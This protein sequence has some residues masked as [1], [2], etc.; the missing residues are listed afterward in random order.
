MPELLIIHHSAIAIP[1]NRQRRTFDEQSIKEL[2]D[3]LASAHGQLHP[4]VLRAD[5][6]TLVCGERRL[7]AVAFLEHSGRS[8]S[9]RDPTTGELTPLPEGCLL[10]HTIGELSTDELEEAELSENI[11]RVDLT[12]QE[13]VEAK[14]RLVRLR[15]KQ[16]PAVTSKEIAKELSP[17]AVPTPSQVTEAVLLAENLHRPEVSAA[18]NAKAAM[19][20]LTRELEHEFRAELARRQDG[21]PLDSRHTLIMGNLHAEL[22]RIASSTVDCIIADPPYGIN[23]DTSFGDMAELDHEYC[24][25]P[26]QADEIYCTLAREGWRI[27]KDMAHAYIF[28]DWTWWERVAEVFGA[29]GWVVWPRPL[30]W[31]K[32]TG[33]LPHPHHGP[34]YTYELLLFANKGNRFVNAV[35]PDVLDIPN[36]KNKQHAAQKPV[37]LYT[38]LLMRSCLPGNVVL[39]PCCGSGT[40]FPAASKASCQAI[41][42]EMSAKHHALALSRIRE[43]KGEALAAL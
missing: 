36:V 37:D 27:G 38:N 12:W 17:A 23:A 9:Y 6:A 33:M 29:A 13:L 39:D 34:R 32:R 20:V 18:P 15:K 7:R 2:A 16:N 4:I 35:Y 24:D 22:P 42:V 11:R 26:E 43:D 21:I 5:R 25:K 14:A 31:W 19:K 8:V 28:L 3:D 41:G 1:E 40:I 10:A 30:V